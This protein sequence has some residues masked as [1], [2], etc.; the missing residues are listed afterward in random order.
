MIR[1][2]EKSRTETGL[3]I[4]SPYKNLKRKNSKIE[5]VLER[6]LRNWELIPIV[7]RR[8]YKK[9]R[10]IEIRRVSHSKRI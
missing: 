8:T 7:I 1:V 2:E 6:A 9:T 10:K 3:K 4:Q 5:W